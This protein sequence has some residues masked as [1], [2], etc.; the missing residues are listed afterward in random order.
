MNSL[1]EF[2]SL[3]LLWTSGPLSLTMSSVEGKRPVPSRRGRAVS[4]VT[5]LVSPR[6]TGLFLLVTLKSGGK[7]HQL[8]ALVDSG[9]AGNFMDI[10]MASRLQVTIDRQPYHPAAHDWLPTEAKQG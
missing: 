8:Q 4:G 3:P 7:L 2:P 5:Q 1:D 6:N 10:A 9:A